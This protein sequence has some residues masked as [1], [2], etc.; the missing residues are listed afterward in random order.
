MANR[1]V[2]GH[3]RT[4]GDPVKKYLSELS[5]GLRIRDRAAKEQLLSTVEKDLRRAAG[6]DP[7][8]EGLVKELGPPRELASKLSDPRNWVVQMGTP[9]MPKVPLVPAISSSG[10]FMLSIFIVA[11][12]VVSGALFAF[13]PPDDIIYPVML[14]VSALIYLLVSTIYYGFIGYSLTYKAMKGSGIGVEPCSRA[15]FDIQLLIAGAAVLL[16]D[17]GMVLYPLSGDTGAVL[18]SAPLGVPPLLLTVA[19]VLMARGSRKVLP[20]GAFHTKNK[21]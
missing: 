7:S 11:M 4:D 8:Y 15:I 14:M 12:F 2:P 19:V 17:A 18:V 6:K 20:L 9:L 21:K 13:L 3:T 16:L 5:V 1:S 10:R